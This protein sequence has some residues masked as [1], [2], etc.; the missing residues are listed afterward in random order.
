MEKKTRQM[1]RASLET[2]VE[3]AALNPIKLGQVLVRAGRI[4]T[5]DL[6]KALREQ[7]A[8]KK[9]IGEILIEKGFIKPEELTHGLNVQS[10]FTTSGI[11]TGLSFG[12]VLEGRNAR[13]C[14]E[15]KA[16]AKSQVPIRS[17]LA[18][19]YQLPSI[20]LSRADIKAGYIILENVSR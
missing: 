6:E 14:E 8:S 10:M 3:K 2:S 20:V 9:R 16:G 7:G 11:S 12:S 5:E 15:K 4:K 1:K 17:H 19:L 13:A 18:I